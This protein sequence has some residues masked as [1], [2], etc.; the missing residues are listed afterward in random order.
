MTKDY[1]DW[2]TWLI[3]QVIA[4]LM[5]MGGFVLLGVLGWL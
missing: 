3:R 4:T 5:F 1:N 2:P